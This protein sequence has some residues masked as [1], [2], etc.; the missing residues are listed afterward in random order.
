MFVKN[1]FFIIEIRNKNLR[2]EDNDYGYADI[3]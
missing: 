3:S 1:A 2:N